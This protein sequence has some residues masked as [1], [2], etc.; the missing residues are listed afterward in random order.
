MTAKLAE[1]VQESHEIVV[2][3]S[4]ATSHRSYGMLGLADASSLEAC[5][6]DRP[7]LTVDRLLFHEALRAESGTAV[8]FSA[9]RE[10]PPS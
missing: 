5:N 6:A 7:L 1:L 4:E 9:F 3:S 10:V 8:Y 2:L